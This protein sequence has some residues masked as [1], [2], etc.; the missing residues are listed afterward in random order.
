M[1]AEEAANELNSLSSTPFPKQTGRAVP[2]LIHKN[3]PKE[4]NASVSW[5]ALCK[6]R[7]SLIGSVM[8]SAA[9]P[10]VL[11]L[12]TNVRKGKYVGV[13]AQVGALCHSKMSERRTSVDRR[14]E[15]LQRDEYEMHIFYRDS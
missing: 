5:A 8:T 12:K 10:I 13:R 7:Q 6:D 3:G 1:V 4:N 11:E 14:P 2:C 9:E 15:L